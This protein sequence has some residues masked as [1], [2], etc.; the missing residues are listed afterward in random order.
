MAKRSPKQPF[1][2]VITIE[3]KQQTIKFRGSHQEMLNK[4]TTK[5]ESD[6]LQRKL[7]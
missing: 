1:R 2:V 3:F 7:L 6:M 5:T 4:H